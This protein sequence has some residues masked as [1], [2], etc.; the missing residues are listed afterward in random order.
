M[1]WSAAITDLSVG[2]IKAARAFLGWSQDELAEYSCV[3]L[4][5]IKRLEAAD[6][7][8]GG[9]VTTVQNIRLS[10]EASGIEFLSARGGGRGVVFREPRPKRRGKRAGKSIAK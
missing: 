5:T 9:R 6:G 8:V 4:P 2:Q 10:F 1:G 7:L 3:S